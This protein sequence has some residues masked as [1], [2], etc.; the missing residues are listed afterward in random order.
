MGLDIHIVSTNSITY[1]GSIRPLNLRPTQHQTA[2]IHDPS[3]GGPNIACRSAA[4]LAL[5]ERRGLRPQ[6]QRKRPR[7]KK[8]QA[9][10]ARARVRARGRAFFAAPELSPRARR[11]DCWPGPRSGQDRPSLQLYP[12]GLAQRPNFRRLR[13]TLPQSAPSA[14]LTPKIPSR[15]PA[16]RISAFPYRSRQTQITVKIE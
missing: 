6:F 14:M 1:S 10:I 7:G 13:A 9:H 8:M 12:A 4:I 16:P 5:L 11:P 15:P 2:S 3:R